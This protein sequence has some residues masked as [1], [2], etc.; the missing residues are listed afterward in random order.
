MVM[1]LM[2]AVPGWKTLVDPTL[3]TRFYGG[4]ATSLAAQ[5]MDLNE[6]ASVAGWEAYYQSPD[7]YRM[8]L[9]TATLPLRNGFTDALLVNNNALGKK[10]ILDTVAFVKQLQGASDSLDMIAQLNEIFFAV[11]FTE[12]T[13]MMLAEEVLMNGGRYYEWATL[14]NAHMADPTKVTAFNAVRTP[15]DRLFKYLFRMAEFQLG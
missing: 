15:L 6:P 12:S 10:P 7:F 2:R 13:T 1:G 8:W 5:Q 11:P 3:E 9:T 4:I 14:W